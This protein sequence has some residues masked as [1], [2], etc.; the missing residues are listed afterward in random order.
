[1]VKF[2]A[3][4][5][6]TIAKKSCFYLC[7]R[8]TSDKKKKKEVYLLLSKYSASLSTSYLY[9]YVFINLYMYMFLYICCGL[10]LFLYMLAIDV[11]KMLIEKQILYH[12]Q[13][14]FLNLPYISLEICDF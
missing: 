11:N 12:N 13:W 4:W 3:L 7:Q 2:N 6:C 1:M 8:L 14:N 9:K 5:F 10:N